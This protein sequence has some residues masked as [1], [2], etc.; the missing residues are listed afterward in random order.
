MHVLWVIQY[1]S[2]AT[3]WLCTICLYR[4][5]CW[6]CDEWEDKVSSSVPC[7]WKHVCP[8]RAKENPS[9]QIPSWEHCAST[10]TTV[11]WRH[12]AFVQTLRARGPARWRHALCTLTLH[13]MTYTVS[14]ITL[15]SSHSGISWHSS[16]FY[17]SS[18]WIKT[19]SLVSC[20][21]SLH[22]ISCHL[23]LCRFI[24]SS[25]RILCHVIYVI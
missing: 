2:P 21:V 5:K 19:L 20:P 17:S 23:M 12:R 8:S 1:C 13:D 11:Q 18:F 9:V 6:L 15:M 25:Q 24:L 4:K 7:R 3:H 22:I 10:K 14:D 16:F